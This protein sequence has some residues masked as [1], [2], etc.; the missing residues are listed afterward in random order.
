MQ[1][2]PIRVIEL[3]DKA[4]KALVDLR[5]EN[6]KETSVKIGEDAWSIP[7]P[8]WVYARLF[9]YRH[10]GETWSDCLLRML[11]ACDWGI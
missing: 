11:A 3:N 5:M 2:R 7:I 8:D 6:V 9:Y 4:Y 10:G 1:G